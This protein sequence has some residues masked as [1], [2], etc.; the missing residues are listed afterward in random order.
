MGRRFIYSKSPKIEVNC[1]MRVQRR[2]WKYGTAEAMQVIAER[3]KR[4]GKRG[5]A[6]VE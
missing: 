5:E 4:R 3:S 1:R 6:K 2:K